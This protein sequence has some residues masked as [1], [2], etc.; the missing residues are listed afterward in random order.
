MTRKYLEF[1]LRESDEEHLEKLPLIQSEPIRLVHGGM[2]YEAAAAQ[3]NIPV[4]TLKTRVHRGRDKV[5]V[6]RAELVAASM[7]KPQSETVD[8]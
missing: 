2:S 8:G 4:N 5:T 6:M 3:L 1:V 7:S